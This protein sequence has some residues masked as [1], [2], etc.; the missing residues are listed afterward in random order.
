MTDDSSEDS[1]LGADLSEY[2]Q[3]MLASLKASDR[4]INSAATR[5]RY[6][7]VGSPQKKSPTRST[8]KVAARVTSPGTGV[9]TAKQNKSPFSASNKPS[10]KRSLKIDSKG[11]DEQG[12][13]D[14]FLQALQDD[15]D[16]T[17]LR[18][19]RDQ[20]RVAVATFNELLS[21]DEDDDDEEPKKK[22]RQRRTHGTRSTRIKQKS[23]SVR[24]RR[25]ASPS[26]AR[27]SRSGYS[28]SGSSVGQR[29]S[30]LKSFQSPRSVQST[31]S[32]HSKLSRKS[33]RS[34]ASAGSVPARI[35]SRR[36]GKEGSLA[37]G[38]NPSPSTIE[39]SLIT[40]KTNKLKPPKQKTKV[41]RS[42]AASR[43]ARKQT[44]CSDTEGGGVSIARLRRLL[45]DA[46][47]R[48]QSL[49]QEVKDLKGR[50]ESSR[51]REQESKD[52]QESSLERIATLEKTVSSQKDRIR[53][54]KGGHSDKQV[55]TLKSEMAAQ[56]RLL[57]A[58]QN[59]LDR[60]RGTL[61]QEREKFRNFSSAAKR[62]QRSEHEPSYSPKATKSQTNY[63]PR[64]LDSSPPPPPPLPATCIE[65]KS[66]RNYGYKEDCLGLS[67]DEDFEEDDDGEDINLM[68][69]S[70][71]PPKTVP[72]RP[73]QLSFPNGLSE[74]EPTEPSRNQDA[75]YRYMK[76]KSLYDAKFH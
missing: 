57:D 11:I 20:H 9:H 26:K 50:L 49:K 1:S 55:A 3:E 6:D 61:V 30:R 56:R 75:Y 23:A 66:R 65:K 36:S 41:S 39:K 43:N 71:G 51:R 73:G 63:S 64:S 74:A 28:S 48:E 27:S 46:K 29:R 4:A 42:T 76:L 45:A 52:R 62:I 12:S 35:R 13:T 44:P 16:E 2:A 22:R 54:L 47:L 25:S 59:K 70:K 67:S 8:P 34:T 72:L 5:I 14:S 18:R 53:K 31:R 32:T 15:D 21:N 40:R 7:P 38:K 24:R 33:T 69:I 37:H 10:S 58:T 60:L 17:L 19:W 68:K